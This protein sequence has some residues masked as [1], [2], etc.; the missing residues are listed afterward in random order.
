MSNAQL[1]VGNGVLSATANTQHTVVAAPAGPAL[2]P[3]LPVLER[4]VVSASRS[5][6]ARLMDVLRST[7]EW[8]RHCSAVRRYLLLG[9]VRWRK[10]GSHIWLQPQMLAK[11]VKIGQAAYAKRLEACGN[12][13]GV[14]H[15]CHG[16]Q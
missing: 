11:H 4:V 9:Q 6:D 5:V 10:T 2:C 3:Q 7:G 15:A 16:V 1:P 12:T 8:D 13:H 14:L